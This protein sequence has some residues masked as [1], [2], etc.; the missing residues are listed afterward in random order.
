MKIICTSLPGCIQNK[1]F[2]ISVWLNDKF[3]YFL[4]KLHVLIFWQ[5][6]PWYFVS[7]FLFFLISFFIY[8]THNS[9]KNST[10]K[11]FFFFMRNRYKMLLFLWTDT[12]CCYFYSIFKFKKDFFFLFMHFAFTVFRESKNSLNGLPFDS[13]SHIWWYEIDLDQ[14]WNKVTKTILLLFSR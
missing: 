9:Q 5:I 13:L 12:K 11:L 8:L 2:Y 14:P 3:T 10:M 4:H 6:F 1:N 7:F